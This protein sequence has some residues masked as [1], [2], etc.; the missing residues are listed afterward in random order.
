MSETSATQNGKQRAVPTAEMA[1]ATRAFGT[2]APDP[3]LRNPDHL[4]SRFIPWSRR[5]TVAAKLSF[6]RRSGRRKFEE[7]VPGAL[8]YETLRTRHMDAE[9][10]A[11]VDAGARQVVV[12]GAGYDSRAYRFADRLRA[13]TVFEVDR[14]AMAALKRRRVKA[15]LKR[16]P[17]NVRYVDID[18]ERQD[19][20]DR[21]RSAGFE[22]G[23][24]TVVIWSGVA[25]YLTQDA[26]DATLQWFGAACAPPSLIVFDHL[27]QDFIEGQLTNDGLDEMRRATKA[28][29]EPLR[30][31]V[32]R[33]G[34]AAW[35]AER[36]LE[37]SIELPP[38]AA[39][40]RYITARGG[41]EDGSAAVVDIGAFISARVPTAR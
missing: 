24:R 7:K 3:Q 6:T 22:H 41:P 33:G 38:T 25:P 1:A 29:G 15:V 31:G 40:A 16:P 11:E 26:I 18:F 39:V 2:A 10:L 19:L 37:L 23:V 36:G 5:P 35:I 21:L 4:A 13:V 17:A 20:G 32:P 9:L 28:A 12:L 27:Y 14:P 30:T 34:A 8:V